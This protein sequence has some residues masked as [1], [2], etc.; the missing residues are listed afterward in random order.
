M[1]GRPPQ[2]EDTKRAS[3]EVRQ[4]VVTFVAFILCLELGNIN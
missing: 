4:D 1:F 2:P 3:K